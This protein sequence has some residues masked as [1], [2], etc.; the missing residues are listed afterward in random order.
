MNALYDIAAPAKLNL[1]L[2]V[3][4]RRADGCHL[5]QS[6]LVL[7]DWCDTLHFELRSDGLLARHDLHTTLPVNDLCLRAAR[8]LQTAS[9]THWGADIS[10]AKQIPWGAGMGGG[11]SDAA[12]TLLA[13]NLLWQLNWPLSRLMSLGLSLGADVP[14]FLGGGHALAEGVGEKLTPL[15]LSPCRFA[16]VKP[17]VHMLTQ[18]VFQS[19]LLVPR[20]EAA[21]ITGYLVNNFTAWWTSG[22][23]NGVVGGLFGV[24]DLQPI[25]QSCC[26][27]VLD[28]ANWLAQ[29]FGNSRMTGS[30]SAV[31]AR[32]GFEDSTV[33]PLTDVPPQSVGRVCCSLE[34]HPLSGWTNQ[35]A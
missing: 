27:Q 2:H 11:S 20:P 3:V 28:S 22:A 32:V 17:P 16:V 23:S 5:L 34:R 7:I 1:F 35:D 15:E 25:V 18:E 6:A 10:I 9:A 29:R 30:G 8:A 33:G 13:L 19:P 21:I 12:S 4:G 14:F 31:F 26:P 24:N